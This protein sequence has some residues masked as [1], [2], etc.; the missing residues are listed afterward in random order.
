MAFLRDVRGLFV[1]NLL[2]TYERR[3]VF[4]PRF[5]FKYFPK[6]Y[7]KIRVRR[8]NSV[9]VFDLSIS[10]WKFVSCFLF[11]ELVKFLTRLSGFGVD[12]LRPF[13]IKVVPR[14]WVDA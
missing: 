2:R 5:D 1:L 7:V 10:G 6:H 14:P 11:E 12:P 3:S 13:S 4:A 9:N 8:C